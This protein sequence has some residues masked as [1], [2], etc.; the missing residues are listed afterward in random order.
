MKAI[1]ILLLS[2]VLLG[3]GAA[4]LANDKVANTK[5]NLSVSGPG[6]V[7]AASD[8]SICIF[9]HTPHNASATAPL[10]NRNDPT[11]TYELYD[12]STFDATPNQPNGSSRL[13]LSCH[14]GTIA[15]GLVKS[16]STPIA[17]AG[18][19]VTLPA[20]KTNVGTS[21]ADDHPVS[22]TY[23]SGLAQTDGELVDPGAL[24]L[25]VKLDQ[26]GRLQ[27]ST[28]HD[29]H[30]N[31]NG[32]FL[33]MSN[34]NAMLCT[35]CHQVDGWSASP[36]RT[37]TATWNG[38][39]TNPWAHTSFNSVS[40]N[41]C[42]NCHNTHSAKKPERLLT[43]AN[44]EDT[45]LVCH[46]GSVAD[47]N[48]QAEVN[49]EFSHPV[50]D[51]LDVH[52]PIEQALSMNKHVECQDCHD[53]HRS[54]TGAAAPA[55]SLPPNMEG[56]AGVATGGTEVNPATRDYQVC[57]KC[58][59]DNNV[60]SNPD[61]QRQVAQINTRLEFSTANPSY[62]PV[63]GAGRNSNVPSL[64]APWTTSS[65]LRCTDCHTTDSNTVKGPHGSTNQY[66]L[67]ANYTTADTASESANAY[68]LC[69]RCHSRTSL[70][71]DDSFEKHKKHIEMGSCSN[72]HDP[73]GISSG[74]G[75][76]VNHSHL[77]NFN[78][79]TVFPNK[80]GKLEFVDTG[81]L[82]GECSL[83]CHNKNHKQADYAK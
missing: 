20:G 26:A 55:P 57:Y 19:I 76:T 43:Q 62:H 80:D 75:S 79:D 28:C 29:P 2:C 66:L 47:K 56:V 58:H 41:G 53:P 39:G 25:E 9:C 46:N 23:D 40:Q 78:V 60:L 7:R 10:W 72:C 24:P 59:G 27:C 65:V 6:P 33:V 68:A 37:S 73:H 35:T 22:F 14:D 31:T 50:G 11:T 36:H 71:E 45:C 38:S 83:K 52:D 61:V 4:A 54:Y 34:Q 44:D 63:E 77:I 67:V 12:S 74:Q 32:S 48:I 13:C 21:L 51:F 1:G 81:N 17:M 3:I 8:T 64:L 18:G 15:L 42:M 30:D 70:L 5:H 16:R 69:Y 82:K 49:K